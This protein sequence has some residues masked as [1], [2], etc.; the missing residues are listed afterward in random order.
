MIHDF[1][2][3]NTSNVGANET[4]IQKKLTKNLYQIG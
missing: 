2:N 1:F 3:M 4:Y